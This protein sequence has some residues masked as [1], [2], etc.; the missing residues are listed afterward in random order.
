MFKAQLKF[1]KIAGIMLIVAFALL[2]IYSLSLLTDV[3]GALYYA[4]SPNI[5]VPEY[6]Q[7]ADPEYLASLGYVKEKVKGAG[8]F[9]EMQD[10]NKLLVGLSLGVIIISLTYFITNSHKR[11][12][13]YIGNYI[14]TGLICASNIAVSAYAFAKI[15]EYRTKFLQV[16]FVAL[17]EFD[18]EI[19]SAIYTESTFWFDIGFVVCAILIAVSVL[20]VI[21]LVWKKSV[22]KKEDN[23]LKNEGV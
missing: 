8:L 21:N 23:L 1:Q 19:Q 17:K 7:D 6:L 10:F 11:R 18:K 20:L 15:I 22:M 14:S 2:F 4:Y 9:Y 12:K 16:D 5:E 3:Y 13:Y